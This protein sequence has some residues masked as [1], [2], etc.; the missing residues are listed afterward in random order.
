[1][2]HLR[3]IRALR[4]TRYGFHLA[5]QGLVALYFHVAAFPL[6]LKNALQEQVTVVVNITVGRWG[7]RLVALHFHVAAFPLELS[8]AF[9]EYVAD[10]GRIRL[11]PLHFH[12]FA[13]PLELSDVLEEELAVVGWVRLLWQ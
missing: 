2:G 8:D 12:V 1:M 7:P 4:R 11:V 5:D 3:N 9:Q 13:L 6:K 10:V